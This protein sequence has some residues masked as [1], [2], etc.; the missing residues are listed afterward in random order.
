MSK[1]YI[2]QQVT[3]AEL[4]DLATLAQ[5]E[6]SDFFARNP[7][8]SELYRNRLIAVALC[9]G[10]ALQF[11]GRGYGVADFDVHFFYNQNPSKPRLSR[12]VKR[13]TADVGNFEHAPIDFVRT[14]VPSLL[15]GSHDNDA[16][17]LLRGFLQQKPTA[18]A[19]HLSK[20]AVVGLIPE[21][22]F[23]RIIWG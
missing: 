11:V 9:Q 3:L 19:A 18:N 16:Q 6:E 15:C 23:G 2:K 14:V 1:T 10:A 12:A 8:L 22:L 5:R 13:L 21:A 17:T 20:K 7:H 4:R